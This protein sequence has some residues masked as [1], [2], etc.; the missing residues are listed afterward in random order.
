M[1][2]L[3]L[4]MLWDVLRQD[5]MQIGILAVGG[6]LGLGYFV[7]GAG[8]SGVDNMPF[9]LVLAAYL[10]VRNRKLEGRR[11][12]LSDYGVCALIIAGMY[13][14]FSVHLKMNVSIHLA[15]TVVLVAEY[16]VWR[17][18]KKG[19]GMEWFFQIAFAANYLFVICSFYGGLR[20]AGTWSAETLAFLPVVLAAF[21]AV[22]LLTY[23]TGDLNLHLLTAVL[24]LNMPRALGWAAGI[25]DH[26]IY[27]V[28]A[29]L[30]LAFGGAC[31]VKWNVIEG[32]PAQ[33]AASDGAAA[34]GAGGES[35]VFKADWF[36]ILAGP[37]VLV[38]A[39]FAPD[40]RWTC[41]YILLGVAW[42]IQYALIPRF[43]RAAF[44]L[45]GILA[46]MAFW[47]QPFITWPELLQLEI[48]LI[49]I[50]VFIWWIGKIW[51]TTP[52]VFNFQTG[53][54][55]LCLLA[56]AL[57]AFYMGRLADALILEGICLTVFLL[58]GMG[59]CR[60]WAYI[61]GGTALGVALYVTRGFWLSISWW[62][63]LLVAGIG[64]ILFA[65][66]NE[67]KKH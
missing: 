23:R 59:K 13:V 55:S 10:L 62:V 21:A 64:L 50:A 16:V 34:D 14:K 54:F 47:A 4:Y 63:Y 33:G 5:H 26:Q 40:R 36:C 25:S 20:M 12:N 45:A 7:H 39:L 60:R 28:A 6:L 49:P 48:C 65:A 41:A 27:G 43:K 29:L 1:A 56:L 58:S 9:F 22:Y 30:L 11:R 51:K 46:V 38:M 24:T 32:I 19:R 8:M 61:S 17:F 2:Y 44:T 52:A 35:P 3:L 18:L 66:R 31:R 42:A 67:M 57:D 37:A 15:L 53:L